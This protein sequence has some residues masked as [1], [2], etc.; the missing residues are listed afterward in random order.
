MSYE[1]FERF[2]DVAD[3]RRIR[4]AAGL[5]DRT[6]EAAEKGLQGT[7]FGVSILHEQA[8][9]GMGRI[10]GDGGCFFQIVDIDHRYRTRIHRYVSK[11]LSHGI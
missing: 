9:V 1:L 5:K 10:I 11:V 2:P 3:Y 4:A 8:T 6:A 7:W